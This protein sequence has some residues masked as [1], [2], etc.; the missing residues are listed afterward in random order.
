MGLRHST[1]KSFKYAFNGAKTAFHREPNLRIHLFF[2]IFA[3]IFGF[4]LEISPTEWV[5]LLFTI[6]FVI[7]LELINTVLEALVN[8]VSPN[9]HPEAKVAKDVSASAVLFAAIISVIVGLVIFGPKFIQLLI[10]G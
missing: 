3:L 7:M 10:T 6:F 5:L 9:F 8:V 2:A 4:L 1:K